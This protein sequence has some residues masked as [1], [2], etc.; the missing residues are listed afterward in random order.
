MLRARRQ[1]RV[2]GCEAAP[3]PALWFEFLPL[4]KGGSYD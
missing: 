4:P 1:R 3:T 2:A